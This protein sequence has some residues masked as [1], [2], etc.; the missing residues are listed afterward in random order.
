MCST[1]FVIDAATGA[2]YDWAKGVAG[3]KY[4]YTLELRDRGDFGFLLPSSQIIPTGE[5]TWAGIQAAV[6]EMDLDKRWVRS[7]GPPKYLVGWA[8]VQ[9]TL[10]IIIA[11]KD[12][13]M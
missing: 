2:S 13:I 7:H 10:P 6:Q 4:S 11:I 8:T 12:G 1:F 5:E 3:I 9:W